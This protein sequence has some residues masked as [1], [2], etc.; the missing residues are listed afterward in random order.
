MSE[1]WLSA[2][3]AARRLGIHPNRLTRL[4]RDG[5]IP[6][7]SYKLGVRSPRYDLAALDSAMAEAEASRDPDH[8]IEAYLEKKRQE[9]ARGAQGTR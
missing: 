4:V 2:Q 6:A 1:R 8:A 9:R 7:P 3:E 5:V